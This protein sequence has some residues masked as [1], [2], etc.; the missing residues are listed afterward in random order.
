MA[1]LKC[2]FDIYYINNNEYTRTG[3]QLVATPV[4]NEV[5]L[6]TEITSI[7]LQPYAPAAVIQ[8]QGTG[9]KPSTQHWIYMNDVAQSQN[10]FQTDA[11]LVK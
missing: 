4:Y 7:S 3:T 6:G 1:A 5:Q 8:F 2:R 11:T 9:L 10:C